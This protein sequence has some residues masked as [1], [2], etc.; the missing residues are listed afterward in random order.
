MEKYLTKAIPLVAEVAAAAV[1]AAVVGE[2]VAM[3]MKMWE[4]LKRRTVFW[5]SV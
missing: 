5:T 2:A 3:K 4:L 1:A